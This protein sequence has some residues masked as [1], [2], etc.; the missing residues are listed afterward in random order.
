M[1]AAC[2]HDRHCMCMSHE[3]CTAMSSLSSSFM[4]HAY[5]LPEQESQWVKFT[6]MDGCSKA[7]LQMAWKGWI[8][9]YGA[10]PPGNQKSDTRWTQRAPAEAKASS[11]HALRSAEAHQ[12]DAAHSLVTQEV[13]RELQDSGFVVLDDVLDA[14]HVD[15]VIT[16]LRTGSYRDSVQRATKLEDH[17]TSGDGMGWRTTR[18]CNATTADGHSRVR[19]GELRDDDGQEHQ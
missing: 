8:K 9:S 1:S 16:P 6:V 17:Q 11:A 7:Q 15:E 19:P 4:D 14:G 2:F 10:I 5:H 18:G 3:S 12:W 13:L